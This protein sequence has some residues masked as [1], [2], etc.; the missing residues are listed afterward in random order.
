MVT[1]EVRQ[2][3]LADI[4]AF[5]DIKR[6]AGVTVEQINARCLREI[7]DDLCIYVSGQ[8]F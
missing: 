2:Y 6:Q 7:V 3:A 1:A 4:D 5:A 8:A